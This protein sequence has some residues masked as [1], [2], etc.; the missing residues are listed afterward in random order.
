MNTNFINYQKI[1]Q[2]NKTFKTLP[3]TD[4]TLYLK[5]Y[6]LDW[7]FLNTLYNQEIEDT[8]QKISEITNKEPEWLF[9]PNDC[10]F[11]T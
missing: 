10:Y 6:D 5:N 4:D 7:R 11:C 8:R 2:Y 3:D 9:L 1:F